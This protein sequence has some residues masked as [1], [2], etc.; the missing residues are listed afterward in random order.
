MWSGISVKKKYILT[1]RQVVTFV[2]VATMTL[3]G[4]TFVR[5]SIVSFFG[6]G[7]FFGLAIFVLTALVGRRAR[8]GVA[9]GGLA[10]GVLF[11]SFDMGV[12]LALAGFAATTVCAT[13]WTGPD[14]HS[15][16]WVKQALGVALVTVVS[17]AAMRGL[18]ADVLALGPFDVVFAQSLQLHL[19]P[20]LAGIPLVWVVT[21]RFPENRK[22]VPVPQRT[23]RDVAAVVLLWGVVGYAVSFV[24][25]AFTLVPGFVIDQELG[26]T[27]GTV[28]QTVSTG[29]LG[30]TLVGLTALTALAVILNRT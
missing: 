10:S 25:E 3:V 29:N 24:F 14:R 21:G 23:R 16:G 4:E 30:T 5:W 28:I 2:A 7:S 19:L 12:T 18:M 20:T 26:R 8:W 17:V 22:Q 6:Q 9:V 1:H 13:I 11:G 15:I 27:A